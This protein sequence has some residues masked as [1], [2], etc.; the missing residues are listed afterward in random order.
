VVG[1]KEPGRRRCRGRRRREEGDE[2]AP[3]PYRVT[4]PLHIVSPIHFR[5]SLCARRTPPQ[6]PHPRPTLLVM[7][8]SMAS[9]GRVQEP[10]AGA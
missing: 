6:D 9:G 2:V 8:S 5:V 7:S 1:K 3:S 4:G 10:K